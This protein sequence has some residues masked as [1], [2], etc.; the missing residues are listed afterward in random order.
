MRDTQFSDIKPV[1]YKAVRV[2][3][4]DGSRMLG[5]WTGDRWWSARGE[6]SPVKWELD[7][8]KKKTKKLLKSLPE[9]PGEKV[10]RQPSSV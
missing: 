8:R 4:A 5:M 9:V 1:A 6:I 2:W 3:V 7:V 10:S